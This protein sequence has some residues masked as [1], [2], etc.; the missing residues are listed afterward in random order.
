MFRFNTNVVKKNITISL[1][2]LNKALDRCIKDR[3]LSNEDVV[4][5]L[6]IYTAAAIGN[7]RR[8]VRD[9]PTDLVEKWEEHYGENLYT[10]AKTLVSTDKT[11]VSRETVFNR[12]VEND[13]TKRELF[14]RLYKDLDNQARHLDKALDL[15]ARLLPPN[16]SVERFTAKDR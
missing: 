13:V 11:N 6:G 16:N 15:V 14:D 12:T 7:Y 4:R 8:G 10:I 9:V 1:K 3:D 5:D 2:P